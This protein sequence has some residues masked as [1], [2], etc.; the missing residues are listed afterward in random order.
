MIKKTTQVIAGLLLLAVC[1]LPFSTV[2]GQG[3]AFT[4]QG[5]LN[6]SGSPANG[7]YDFRFKLYFD[8]LGNTQTGGSYPT[9]AIPVNNGLFTVAIDFGTGIFAGSNYWLEV[10]VRTNNAANYSV[11]TPL[12]AVTPTPEAIF[13]ESA[14]GLAT[15]LAATNISGT[16]PLTH[17]P[18]G[19]VTNNESSVTL[20]N[21][22]VGGSLILTN[23]AICWYSNGDTLL[24]TDTNFDIFVGQGTGD[25]I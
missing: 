13:A 11:L 12:Q 1:N 9:N 2:F 18:A 7:L 8:P 20:S 19:V 4:Y 6:N 24:I 23:S 10:D 14:N 25:R 22:I 5:R 3:T 15:P 21:V 17:L 16:I